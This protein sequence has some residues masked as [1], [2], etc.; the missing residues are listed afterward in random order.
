MPCTAPRPVQAAVC[1]LIKA[2]LDAHAARHP[3][4][5]RP[6]VRGAQ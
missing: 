1:A 5:E 2:I 6:P 4:R 3:S